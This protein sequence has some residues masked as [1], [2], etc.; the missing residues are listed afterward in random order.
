MAFL[1]CS[2]AL[3][4]IIQRFLAARTLSAR[5]WILAL[6][7]IGALFGASV[8][9][10][11]LIFMAVKTGLH[12]HGPEFTQDQVSWVLRQIPLWGVV[13]LIGGLGLGLVT[14]NLAK[15]D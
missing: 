4:I 13:G 12:S 1:I 2:L 14:A 9:L 11:T 6:A 7:S 3:G 15:N 10:L 8:A 5:N